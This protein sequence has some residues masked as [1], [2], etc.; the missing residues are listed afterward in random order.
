METVS[1]AVCGSREYDVL[2][3]KLEFCHA[4]AFDPHK[5]VLHVGE[6]PVNYQ[7]VCCRGCGFIY[8]NPR[9]SQAEILDFYRADYRAL[10]TTGRNG[11][12][13]KNASFTREHLGIEIYNAVLRYDYLAESKLLCQGIKTL[14]VGCSLG[15]LPAY[16][17]HSGAHAY[18]IEVSPYAEEG[19]RL[20]G[21]STIHEQPVESYDRESGFDIVTLCDV[22]E[23][24]ADPVLALN[25]IRELMSDS[26]VLLI[27]VPDLFRP[28]KSV[29]T[30]FSNVHVS[31]F[32]R[33]SIVN[34]LGRCGF[35]VTD[36]GYGG[37][38]KNMRILARKGPVVDIE[39]RDHLVT[40]SDLIMN[41]DRSYDAWQRCAHGKIDYATARDIID[42]VLP[43]STTLD[44]LEG[45]R[46]MGE[47][48]YREAQAFLLRCAE[49]D[50]NEEDLHLHPGSVYSL[51]A[52]CACNTGDHKRF[53]RYLSRALH[54]APRLHRF[55]YLDNLKMR[56]IFDM[57]EFIT[58]RGLP[59]ERLREL[60]QA[61]NDSRQPTTRE[62]MQ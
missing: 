17:S 5:H 28:H 25:R 40:V 11:T 20:F 45:T 2:I 34:L 60:E 48:R 32:S 29:M 37:F 57:D 19:R 35:S 3:D 7:H 42:E 59:Y 13:D 53:Q 38:C 41:Y 44:Y 16:L 51:L 49:G 22:L 56:G 43:E 33:T 52:L 6:Q 55:P 23:H 18:G 21:L 24:L 61:W 10:Y 9:M 62:M 8:I 26:G 50:F 1:C 46:L 39:G 30:F 14:D 12:P 36:L 31:T 58:L 15:A 54:H 47:R 27:E 4:H